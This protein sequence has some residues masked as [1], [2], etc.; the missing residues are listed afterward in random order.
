MTTSP[1]DIPTLADLYN[2]NEI[3]KANDDSKYN[4]DEALN[5]RI[6]IWRGDITKLEADVIVNAANS[7]LL[8][9][10]GVDG[11]IHRAAGSNLLEEC[12]TLG[13]AKTGETKLTKA[14]KLPSKFIAHT[15]GPIYSSSKKEECELN[16]KSCYSTSLELCKNNGGGSIG[17]SS[18]STG[19]YGYPIQDA[20]E[21]AIET[22]RTIL[23]KDE[24]ITRVI[25]VVFSQRDEDVYKSIIPKYFPPSSLSS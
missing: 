15:V 4:Y 18:I 12:K 5:K 11:A 21:I 9:G 2:S 7:S 14:Y 19:V 10:G 3:S 23:E 17:F 22:T 20:T 25:Y 24:T 8:G 6:S 13:G 16:L 1:N